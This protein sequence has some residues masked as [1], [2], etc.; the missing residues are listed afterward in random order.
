MCGPARG[1]NISVHLIPVSRL[2]YP[3]ACKGGVSGKRE[4]VEDFLIFA[5]EVFIDL[6]DENNAV[7]TV[8]S[9]APN[10]S[11]SSLSSRYGSTLVS[12]SSC[13]WMTTGTHPASPNQQIKVFP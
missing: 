13:P 6:F 9:K 2:S 5:G 12:A 3:H 7:I 1:N 11:N 8:V 4:I 10:A